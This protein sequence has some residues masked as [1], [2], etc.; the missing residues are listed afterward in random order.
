MPRRSQYL[1]NAGCCSRAKR[2]QKHVRPARWIGRRRYA[3]PAKRKRMHRQTLIARTFQFCSKFCLGISTPRFLCGALLHGFV[4]KVTGVNTELPTSIEPQKDARE[5]PP[6]IDGKLAWTLRG[7]MPA[8]SLAAQRKRSEQTL[9]DGPSKLLEECKNAKKEESQKPLPD[10]SL[11]NDGWTEVTRKKHAEKTPVASTDH[12]DLLD[13]L[14]TIVNTCRIHTNKPRTQMD[15]SKNCKTWFANTPVNKNLPDMFVLILPLLK[16]KMLLLPTVMSKMPRSLLHPSRC[17][18]THHVS[19]RTMPILRKRKARK[20]LSSR[21]PKPY[22][23]PWG[24]RAERR[25]Q[26]PGWLHELSKRINAALRHSVGCRQDKKTFS[27]MPCDEGAWVNIE[28]LMKYDLLWKNSHVLDGTD[29]ADWRKVI[30]RWNPFIQVIC[31]EFR[32]LH[33]ARAQILELKGQV[34]N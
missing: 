3:V 7:G 20:L 17:I 26:V 30:E 22:K 21:P 12:S 33:R 2:T 29:T 13:D 19:H 11:R 4:L 9:L 10:T 34:V 6:K 8:G 31:T 32:N 5:A 23:Y 18:L 14:Q 16:R 28:N 27:G 1:V 24:F 15:Y 25:G